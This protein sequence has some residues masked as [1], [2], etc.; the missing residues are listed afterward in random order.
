M[1][2]AGCSTGSEE[3]TILVSA[4][5]SLGP[6]FTDIATAYEADHGDV[7]VQLNLGGSTTLAEQI[8][9]GAP[10]AVF[11][12][13]DRDA[14]Q[15]V[16]EVSPV[17]AV[18]RVFATNS[19]TI[20]VPVGNP[21]GISG[22]EDFEN[23]DLFLG[24]CAVPV[25]C[26]VYAHEVLDNASVVPSIDTEE[27]DVTSL[28]LKIELGE[29]DGGIVYATDVFSR[30]GSIGQVAIPDDYNVTAS[31]LIALLETDSDMAAGFVD[32]VFSDVGRAILVEH[33]F[34]VP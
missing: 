23:P 7:A 3:S 28:A 22:L 8:N 14:M 19:L 13:A 33:G 1:P 5:A 9:A 30:Q 31:Y 2:V 29:L 27:S 4:A 26:G 18:Q 12:S 24:L 10:V 34:G 16:V 6:A 11:A 20:A 17:D 25:P 32:F 15:R 21:G